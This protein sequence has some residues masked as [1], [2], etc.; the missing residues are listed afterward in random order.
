MRET[1]TVSIPDEVVMSKI[2]V[3]RNQKIMLDEDLAELYGVETRRL[4]EQVRRN[5][6]RLPED[7]F[8]TLNVQEFADLKSQN[9]TSSWGGQRKL[10]NAF[11]EH[12]VS[13]L[14]QCAEQ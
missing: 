6:D 10:P 11:T 9:A 8:F 5:P 3:I 14:S 1:N 2:Y 7:F 12:G 13:M 4:N